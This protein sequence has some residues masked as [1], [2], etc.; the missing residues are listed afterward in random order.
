VCLALVGRYTS[1]RLGAF[2]ERSPYEITKGES[3]LSL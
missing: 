3:R 1:G 2:G